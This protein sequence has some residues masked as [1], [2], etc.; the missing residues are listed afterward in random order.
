VAATKRK[1]PGRPSGRFTQSRRLGKLRTL[2]EGHPG[3]LPLEDLAG[4]IH[5]S[6]R[7]VR[8][9]L[10]ELERFTEIESIET[11]PGGP[12]LW[13]IKPSE[14]GRAV[15]L[16][17]TQAYALLAA[18]H[19]FDALKGSA[20]HDEVDT[21][22][23]LLLQLAQ[24][25]GRSLAGDV[26]P[27][28]RLEDRFL[29]LR[30]IAR[31]YASKSEQLDDL[32]GA[33]AQLRS[34][35]IRERSN[36]HQV[37][38]IECDPCALVVRDGSIACIARVHGAMHVFPLEHIESTHVLE[39]RFQLPDGFN[40]R[41]YVQGVFGLA[42]P[43][44]THRVIVEFDARIADEVRARK[45]HPSQRVATSPDGRVRLAVEVPRLDTVVSW[46]LSFGDAAR[47]IEP[48]ELVA[49]VRVALDRA[50]AKYR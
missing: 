11:V 22:F 47:V 27:D 17:R 8:R 42:L 5:V 50:H 41:D 15:P 7:S 46:V 23:G 43:G 1:E 9:Y 18:R 13:R 16:R 37:R 19:A 34:V 14:R 6:T 35:R 33:A 28:T 24:R 21:L 10:R 30:D 3:G 48:P 44:P 38:E 32:F 26:P 25:P 36:K 29:V 2:L 45:I 49:R 12:H 20:L 4:A 39:R 31:S 40:A